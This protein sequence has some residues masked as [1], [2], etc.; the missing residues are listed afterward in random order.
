MR[1]FIL[2]LMIF[3]SSYSLV[4]QPKWY[5]NPPESKT[6]D[7]YYFPG[8]G[9]TPVRAIVEAKSLLA[10]TRGISEY[11]QVTKIVDRISDDRLTEEVLDSVIFKIAKVKLYT[12]PA[13]APTK[14][15]SNYYVLLGSPKDVFDTSSVGGRMPTNKFLTRSIVPG[16]AQLYNKE[17]GKGLLFIIGE[18]A[19]IG[20]TLGSFSQASNQADNAGL[21]FLSGNLAQYNSFQQSEDNW[22]TTGTILGISAAALWV[23]NIIDAT[24]S[25]KN[26]FVQ[27]HMKNG[28]GLLASR[29]GFGLKYSF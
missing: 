19:L 10:Q 23:L 28:M 3:G 24:A 21:A 7:Y 1:F 2:L 17:S 13:I 14:K 5:N 25:K 8:E 15:G 6:E 9:S 27:M 18:I 4:S 11:S 16:W 22:K 20:G 26:I 29:K 12:F